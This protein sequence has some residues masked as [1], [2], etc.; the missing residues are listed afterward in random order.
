M[1]PL[2]YSSIPGFAEAAKDEKNARELSFLAK[3]LPVAG[4]EVNHLTPRLWLMLSHMEC[5]FVTGE[6]PQA[7]DVA[8][9][10]WLCSPLY[11][12]DAAARA[13][14]V[15]N[16]VSPLMYLETCREIYR[17]LET[18]FIDAPPS[19][20]SGDGRA[21]WAPVASLV[22]FMADAYGW[23]DEQ[24]LDKPLARI[25]QY[26]KI[27]RHRRNPREPK[28]NRSDSLISKWLAD[29]NGGAN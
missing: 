12:R 23:D 17:Y 7:E 3:T 28:F 9:F 16:V 18:V 15:Q 6:A 25:F 8:R 20:G 14:Y 10:F 19:A 2:D 26:A 1:G 24:I 27:L 29:Q 22:H 5:A 21:Y 11:K 13:E 4:I